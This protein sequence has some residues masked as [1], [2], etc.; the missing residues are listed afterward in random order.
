MGELYDLSEIRE[1]SGND[2]SF[3]KEM[4]ELFVKNNLI[5]LEELNDAFQK[6]DWKQV[7]FFAHKI[8]PS[9]LV[10]HAKQLVQPILDLN[11]YAGN[12]TNINEIPDIMK[13]LNDQLPL[14]CDQ[15]K[16]E[17]NDC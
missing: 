3:V 13:K 5:Y 7:K 2:E 6:E 10:I 4:I 14:I 9:I 1:M 16:L 17:I 8:K 12:Q 15:L 11:E